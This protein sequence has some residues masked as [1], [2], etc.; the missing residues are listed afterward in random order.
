MGGVRKWHERQH[1]SCKYDRAPNA[2]GRRPRSYRDTP[3]STSDW[4]DSASL[5][6]RRSLAGPS[7][8]DR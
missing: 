2:V 3:T 6:R 4:A 1:S 8:Q 5:V 7:F